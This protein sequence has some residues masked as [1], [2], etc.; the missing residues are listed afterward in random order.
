VRVGPDAVLG[1]VGRGWSQTT[2][3]LALERGGPT[4]SCLSTPWWRRSCARLTRPGSEARRGDSSAG[5]GD[6]LG[7]ARN[8]ALS[9]A[10]A[11]D[12]GESSVPRG[13]PSKEMA[14]RFEQDIITGLLDV[15]DLQPACDSPS[16]LSSGSCARRSSP[17]PVFTIRGGT[18]EILRSVP[19]RP[20]RP[21]PSARPARRGRGKAMTDSLLTDT[22]GEIFAAVCTDDSA[23]RG[24]T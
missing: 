3:E 16:G 20:S 19:R 24:G 18:S 9:I 1:D 14:T 8:L 22:V 6:L 12:S 11:V 5:P 17:G 23:A 10:R 13:R 15:I 2:A 7:D 21:A 4:A